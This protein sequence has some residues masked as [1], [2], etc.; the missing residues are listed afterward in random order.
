MSQDATHRFVTDAEKRAWDGTYEQSTGYTD[1][2]IADL[3]GGDP[4]TLGT[5]KDFAEAVKENGDLI[6]GLD[7]AIG[8][9]ADKAELDTH[10]GN[11]AIHVTATDKA[12]WDT[13]IAERAVGFTQATSRVN[14]ASGEK[15][16]AALGKIRKWFADLEEV[17]FTGSYDDLLDRPA[18]PKAVRVKGEKEE[19][20]RTG[21]V[22]LAAGDIGLERYHTYSLTST[23]ANMDADL[24]AFFSTLPDECFTIYLAAGATYRVD[25]YK[26]GRYGVLR[27]GIYVSAKK[28]VQEQVCAC[29][30]GVWGSWH[31]VYTDAYKPTPAGIGAVPSEYLEGH[32]I[33]DDVSKKFV[34]FPAAAGWYKIAVLNNADATGQPCMVTIKRFFAHNPGETHKISFINSTNK[35]VFSA[36]YDTSYAASVHLVKKIRFVKGAGGKCYLEVY[37]SGTYQNDCE[38][39]IENALTIGNGV[40]RVWE[41]TGLEK[42]TE[43]PAAGSVAA[44]YDIPEK[45]NMDMLARNDYLESLF[46]AGHASQKTFM[47]EGVGWKKIAEVGEGDVSTG[48]CIIDIKRQY[49]NMNNEYHR[50]MFLNTYKKYEFCPVADKTN[51]QTVLKA[52]VVTGAAG[53][54]FIEIYYNLALKNPVTVTIENANVPFQLSTD[55]HWEAIDPINDTETPAEGTVAATYEIP[56]F[57][58]TGMLAMKDGSNVDGVWGDLAAGEVYGRYTQNSGLQAPGYVPT[59]RVRFNMMRQFKGLTD[60]AGTYMDCM[61]MNCYDGNDVP[62]VTALGIRKGDGNPRAFIAVGQKNNND[63]WESQAE[64]ITTANYKDYL[65]SGGSIPGASN[66]QIKK[67]LFSGALKSGMQDFWTSEASGDDPESYEP[68]PNGRKYVIARIIGGIYADVSNIFVSEVALVRSTAY[69]S[70]SC[71]YVQMSINVYPVFNGE[72]MT[73]NGYIGLAYAPNECSAGANGKITVDMSKASN[74]TL[75]RLELLY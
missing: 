50:L 28:A 43:A 63:A 49:G 24:K 30:D 42:D 41:A 61:L 59:N 3:I 65:G 73:A 32:F 9:K 37:Y 15:L 35:Y 7:D 19:S 38:V 66:A 64:L 68:V 46:V 27:K 25:G 16:K 71:D 39:T 26:M 10:V 75:L 54:C 62:Y 23:S 11:S 21:D 53:K 40:R 55:S 12:N 17:A 51:I 1:Q 4:E 5:L 69:N 44:V 45:F 72:K 14:I 56:T 29:L 18:V 70:N 13:D 47:L 6:K 33:A 60:I 20:Y 52:R 36:V 34:D 8:K 31:T 58:N 48:S 67:V 74:L 22:N 2:K 57:F